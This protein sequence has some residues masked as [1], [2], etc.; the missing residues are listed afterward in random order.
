MAHRPNSS[1]DDTSEASA[2]GNDVAN[3]SSRTSPMLD[4]LK[5]LL[6]RL[7]GR[8]YNPST[9]AT[10]LRALYSKNIQIRLQ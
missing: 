8:S 10:E 6:P 1:D 5:A 3:C 4:L 9:L 2:R 7:R